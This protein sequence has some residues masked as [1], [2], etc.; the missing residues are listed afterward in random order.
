MQVVILAAGMGRR[1]GNLTAHDTKCMLEVNGETLIKRSLDIISQFKISR[2]IL[3]VGFARQ[4]LIDYLGNS[5]KG[6][7]IKYIENKIYDKTNNIYSLYLAKEY[8]SQEDTLLLESDLIYEKEIINKL[9]NQSFPNLAV[10]DKYKSWMDGTVVTLNKDDDI[11]SII[12]KKNFEHSN[13]PNYYKTVNIYKFSKEFMKKSYLPFLEAYSSALGHNEYYEQVLRVL[14]TLEQQNLKAVR[15]S[16]E[17]WYEIDDVQDLNNAEAI[18]APPDLKLSYFQNRFG[19]YWRYPS[20]RDY[21][22]LVNPYF[23]TERMQHEM[24]YYFKELLSEYPSGQEVQNLLA[25]KTFNC[26]KDQILVGNGAAELIYG[27]FSNWEGRIGVIY[28]TFNEY[29]ERMNNATIINFLP[30]NSSFSYTSNDLKE[31]SYSSNID[32]LLLINPDNPSGNFIPISDVLDLANYLKKQKKTLVLDESFVD[33]SEKGAANSLIK[34]S[35]LDNLDNL[36]IIKSISKSYGVPGARLGVI[37][38]SNKLIMERIRSCLSIWN[39]NS[40]AEFFLQIIG[41]Y[42]VDYENSCREIRAERDRFYQMLKKIPF[43]RPIPSQANYFLCEVLTP[44]TATSLTCTILDRYDIFIKDCTGKVGFDKK[45]YIRIA[46]RDTTDN[47]FFINALLKL[48]Q[49][50]KGK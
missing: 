16:G 3:V 24:E 31:F 12:P 45:E 18:F 11:L 20:I 39:I 46:V 44:W 40:F 42:I 47:E 22:Y 19:G 49:Q 8:L 48:T 36:I 38:T 28:P 35:I 37:A 41:K 50:T 15:L 5:Y 13:I 25:A 26:R 23:P 1:L 14:L 10:V 34:E 17:K 4:R 30:K 43:L 7:P 2:I 32:T 6:I 21:C 9:L 29:P 27:L 33:F